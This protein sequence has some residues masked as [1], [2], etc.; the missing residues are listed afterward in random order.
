MLGVH[1]FNN[2]MGYLEKMIY[3]APL[4]TQYLTIAKAR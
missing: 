1:L 4:K 3:D 2:T